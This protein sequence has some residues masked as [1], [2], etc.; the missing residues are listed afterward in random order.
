LITHYFELAVRSLKRNAVLTAMMIAAIGL[1][2]GASMTMLT[3]L[4]V[5]TRDP[6]P[7]RSDTLFVPHIDPLPAAFK[8]PPASV[9]PSDLF[10]YPDAMA[11]VSAR[12]ATH[13]AAMAGTSMPVTLPQGGMR[14]FNANGRIAT[15]DFFP[16]FDVKLSAGHAWLAHD[17]DAHSRVVVLSESLSRRL[18]GDIKAVGKVVKLGDHAFSVIGV[19]RDWAP[20]PLFYADPNAKVFGKP[21]EFFIPL[22]TGIEFNIDPQSSFTTWTS[23]FGG[24]LMKDAKT[25]WLQFWVQLDTPDARTSYR[26]FLYNYAAEQ[27]SLGRFER[28]PDSVGLYGLMDWLAHESLV[29]NDV[30]IQMLLAIAF[31]VVCITNITALLLT[32][33]MRRNGEVGLRRALGATRSDIL[34]QFA[35]E[36]VMVGLA[37]GLLGVLAAQAGLWLVRQRPDDYAKLA[38]MDIQMLAVTILLAVLSAVLAG[39][40]PAWRMSRIAPALQLKVA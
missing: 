13:Q 14:A 8:K 28:S 10:T 2:V 22:S 33:F 36:S 25:T 16:M 34:F 32:K 19:S 21:D 30:R 9:E 39:L 6:M 26:Q 15:A 31:L 18:F 12:K 7:G 20:K 27:R 40:L 23:D 11:L 24:N 4:H 5:L 17:D 29:P 38:T 3:V 37:G 1:G 35:I